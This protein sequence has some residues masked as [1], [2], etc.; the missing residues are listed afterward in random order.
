MNPWIVIILGGL[1]TL[2]IRSSIIL[3]IDKITM[4]GW[5]KR[6]LRYIPTAILSAVILPGLFAPD[7][8]MAFSIHN[9]ELLSGLVAIGVAW[10]TKNVVLT[11]LIGTASLVIL[12][13]VLGGL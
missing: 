2:G 10:W 11:I 12:R 6:S 8:K 4:P 13:F 7:G 1:F 3:T 5:F 9:T